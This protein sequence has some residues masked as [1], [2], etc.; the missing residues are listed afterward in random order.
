MPLSVPVLCYRVNAGRRGSARPLA[1]A[2]CNL[3]GGALP[4]PAQHSRTGTGMNAGVEKLQRGGHGACGASTSN[5]SCGEAAEGKVWSPHP[6]QTQPPPPP[7]SSLLGPLMAKPA[8]T[9]GIADAESS[10]AIVPAAQAAP[11]TTTVVDLLRSRPDMG[12]LLGYL[13]VSGEREGQQ[14]GGRKCGAAA[15]EGRPARTPAVGQRLV[16]G[17]PLR[18]VVRHAVQRH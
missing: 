9:P 5:L 7:S 12:K 4:R 18:A 3:E 2:P 15:R 6:T 8:G 14:A 17:T 10:A 1:Q 16:H 13:Q 11:C